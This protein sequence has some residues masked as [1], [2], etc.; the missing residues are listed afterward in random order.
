MPKDKHAKTFH[1]LDK[2]VASSRLAVPSALAVPMRDG[3]GTEIAALAFGL[4]GQKRQ[5]KRCPDGQHSDFQKSP[6][7]ES[8][9]KKSRLTRDGRNVQFD[10]QA[11]KIKKTFE[12][13]QKKLL[14]DNHLNEN[15]GTSQNSDTAA[16]SLSSKL[17]RSVRKD[18]RTLE[19]YVTR[20]EVDIRL[21]IDTGREDT[22]QQTVDENAAD[23]LCREEFEPPLELDA[24][25]SG[26]ENQDPGESALECHEE[27]DGLDK[28]YAEISSSTKV[29]FE[30]M[31]TESILV[32]ARDVAMIR[33]LTQ[34]IRKKTIEL[35]MMRR[36]KKY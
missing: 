2:A 36:G 29:G 4:S 16:S 5:V 11:E 13:I 9:K 24:S 23:L 33:G 25:N 27:L 30:R 3:N 19:E 8:L 28:G 17:L 26:N 21:D 20:A 31:S 10:L 35:S 1:I 7:A 15:G 6:G 12:E 34:I 14:A 22:S 18:M 32:V